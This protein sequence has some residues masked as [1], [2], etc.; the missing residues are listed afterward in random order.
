MK[1]LRKSYQSAVVGMV[2]VGILVVAASLRVAYRGIVVVQVDH[3]ARVASCA[4]AAVMAADSLPSASVALVVA[5]CQRTVV[6]VEA[7]V[8]VVEEPAEVVVPLMA[9]AAAYDPV[10]Q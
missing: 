4:V 10:D 7:F 6:A 1:I 3:F 5:E 8:M 2:A 9:S